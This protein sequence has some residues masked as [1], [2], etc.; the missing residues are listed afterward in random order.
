MISIR[1][2]FFVLLLFVGQSLFSQIFNG[3]VKYET[4]ENAIGVYV[5]NINQ[6]THAHTDENG[7][8]VINEIIKGDT[9]R[10]SQ[11]GY[12]T[13]MVVFQ[14]Y[15]EPLLVKLN[16]KAAL[17]DEVVIKPTLDALNVI[18]A[19]DINSR[20]VASSQEILRQVP[21]L[22]IGQHAGGGKAEQIFLRGFDIDHGTD[23]AISVDEIPVNMVSHAHGQGYA[24]LHFLIPE[25]ID[26]IDFGKGPYYA[27]Q[28]N[29]NTAA[30]VS[31]N[32]KEKIEDSKIKFE[33]GQFNTKRLVAL[34]D[35]LDEEEAGFD[36]YSAFEYIS[37][38]GYFESPQNFERINIFNK[39]S[40]QISDREKINLTLSHFT[41]S[42]DASGQIPVRAVEQN[43]IT[44][45][46]A[47]DDTEGGNTSRTNVVLKHKKF[48]SDNT[49]I[50]NNFYF[51][52]YDF[53]LYSNF[54][55]FLDD[56]INGDQIRQKENRNLFGL[57]SV[58]NHNFKISHIDVDFKAGVQFRK[59]KSK[60]NELS[61]TAN[62]TDIIERIR[63][64]SIDETNLG[65]FV[66]GSFTLDKFTLFTGLRYDFFNFHYNDELSTQ[67]SRQTLNKAIISPKASLLYAHSRNLQLYLKGGKG[68]HSNDTRV[69]VAE[70]DQKTLPAAYGFDAGFIWKPHPHIFINSAYW[71]L[72]SEQEF[73]YVGDAGIVEPSGASRRKGVD[74]SFRYQ[75]E[76]YILFDLDANYTIARTN[77][78]E[79]INNYIPLAPDF[80]LM[81]GIQMNHKSGLQGG[82][83]V[84]HLRNRP[85][86]EDNSIV[87]EGYTVADLNLAYEKSNV[88]IGFQIKNVFNT[89]WNEAQFA[90]ESRLQNEIEPVEELHFT[91]GTPF[92]LNTMIEFKF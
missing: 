25:T 10:F 4:G 59:D 13:K 89:E 47:I 57:K 80:T 64:G 15:E 20:P 83:Q 42:W 24:D 78:D 43:L 26:N 41:S 39:F 87:A 8:F 70:T 56:P 19:I 11:I 58:L 81:S 6:N 92:F 50:D 34:V 33:L 55:F 79:P 3:Q 17:L 86:N 90:T 22:F 60:D 35:V 71:F 61:H 84:Q 65:G 66:N 32:T 53:E 36:F 69:V 30:Y 14:N 18:T 29:F 12:E 9:L 49:Y 75:P 23:I 62:R 73:V 1:Y 54:T 85:A 82:I 77:L 46:G 51:S 68:F 38:D 44:R 27:E 63:L 45:F 88:R 76:K 72:Y 2:I 7:R 67:F 48:L 21:G 37:T 28:G 40:K 16:V 31:F 91:P 52:R 5:F 74:L